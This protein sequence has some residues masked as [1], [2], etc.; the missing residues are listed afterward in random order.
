MESI[1]QIEELQKKT[2][3]KTKKLKLL[4]TVWLCLQY[5]SNNPNDK[6]KV[7]IFWFDESHFMINTSIFG[8]FVN[9]KPNTMNRLFRTHGFHYQKS[10]STMRDKVYELYPN[11]TLP[12]PKNWIL[13]WCDGFTRSTTEEEARK[14]K[15][16]QLQEKN[17]KKKELNLSEEEETLNFNM[18]INFDIMDMFYPKNLFSNNSI[19]YDSLIKNE[20]DNFGL[21]F[22]KDDLS[23]QLENGNDNF[24]LF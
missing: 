10:T 13:R 22:E 1:R 21:V 4:H 24:S 23:K 6:S 7:G 9:R 19:D 2:T 14:W 17:P 20:P 11:E 3:D 5:V 15:K 18:P 16:V 12:E 8:I